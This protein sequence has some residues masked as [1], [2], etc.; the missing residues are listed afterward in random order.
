LRRGAER[1]VPVPE[2]DYAGGLSS[3]PA[4]TAHPPQ[5]GSSARSNA[6][7]ADAPILGILL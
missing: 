7:I 6:W 4:E 5:H 1:L 3:S 2:D